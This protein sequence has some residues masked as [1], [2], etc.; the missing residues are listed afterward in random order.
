MVTH[1]N[2][3]TIIEGFR[4]KRVYIAFLADFHF[5]RIELSFGIVP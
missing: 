3:E 4:A 2:L 1:F 5:F